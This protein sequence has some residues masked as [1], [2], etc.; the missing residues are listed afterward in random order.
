MSRWMSTGFDPEQ[1]DPVTEPNAQT[2]PLTGAR[3]AP[4]QT[5]GLDFATP[6]EF[7]T[8]SAH[9]SGHELA[10]AVKTWSHVSERWVPQVGIF[11][12]V[13]RTDR[14][15]HAPPLATRIRTRSRG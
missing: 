8:V 1:M 4:L 2:A 12:E 11:D 9:S 6:S 15:V 5:E 3:D 13:S 7:G 14:R 10:G